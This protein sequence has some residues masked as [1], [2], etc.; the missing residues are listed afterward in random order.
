MQEP[1]QIP[2]E[3]VITGLQ[4]TDGLA[5]SHTAG[6]LVADVR[7]SRIFRITG[8]T[9]AAMFKDNTGAAT[10]IA[11]DVQGRIYMCESTTRRVSRMD[12]QGG[13]VEPLAETFQGKK[14]NAPNDIVVRRDYHVFFTDPAFGSANDRRELDYYGIFH[15]TPKGETDV[16]AQWK[17]R[18]NG[19][20]LTADGRILYVA[21][22]DRHAVVA[23]DVDKNGAPTNQRDVIKNIAGVPGGI[24]TDMEGRIYVCARGVSIYSAAGKFQRTLLEG[25]NVS[26]CAFGEENLESLYMTSRGSVYKAEVGVKG[27]LQY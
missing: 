7:A 25:D 19:L 10:G 4:F 3:R 1:A 14:F 22:S 9:K 13:G 23:W 21:D 27:A 8:P 15:I 12:R 20:A 16:I 6:M 11:C 17:T 26:N 5:W 24:K 2:L 18:P